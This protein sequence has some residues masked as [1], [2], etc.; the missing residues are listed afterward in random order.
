MEEKR[1]R[2][3]EQ[4]VG[5]T[6][7][8]I[9]GDAIDTQWMRL[10]ETREAFRRLPPFGDAMRNEEEVL[11][12]RLASI[13]P[14]AGAVDYPFGIGSRE[15]RRACGTS[16]RSAS[17]QWQAKALRCCSVVSWWVERRPMSLRPWLCLQVRRDRLATADV[18]L[19]A[20]AGLSG[21][22]WLDI[23]GS[24]RCPSIMSSR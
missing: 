15:D 24:R 2:R 11:V 19:V 17:V 23:G 14:T 8:E 3:L 4:G 5:I 12:G 1:A 10:A 21:V 16:P 7:P 6:W 9:W 18:R 13:R 22:S 20:R